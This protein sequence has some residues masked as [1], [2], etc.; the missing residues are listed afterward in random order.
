M[1]WRGVGEQ[2]SR[3]LGAVE[4]EMG[5]AGIRGKGP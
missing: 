4:G 2:G 1:V 3:S 5:T